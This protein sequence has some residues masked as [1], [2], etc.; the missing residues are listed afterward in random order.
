MVKTVIIRSNNGKSDLLSSMGSDLKETRIT[1]F[2]GYLLSLRPTNLL[3]LFQIKDER[4]ISVQI[5]RKLK[6]Q[7]CDIIVR[8]SAVDYIIEAKLFYEDPT[9]QLLKQKLEYKNIS[10]SEIK[11]IG[12][13][14]N[15]SIENSKAA[16]FDWNDIYNC[17]NDSQSIKI[18]ILCEELKLHLENNGLVKI[19]TPD[20]YAR[21]VADLTS[22]NMFLKAQIYYCPY[23]KSSKIEKCKY[24]APHFS[25][26]IIK[27]SPGINYGI[28]YVAKICG[29]EYVENIDDL[30]KV[31]FQHI[32]AN[33]LRSLFPEVSDIVKNI[34]IPSKKAQILL[35][36][37]KPHLLFNPPIQ[38]DKLQEGSGWLSK[39]YFSFEDFFE[40]ANL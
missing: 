28:S 19:D 1:G 32:K 25:K 7:R 14:N 4:I 13:T 40:A 10:Q 22:L 33:K 9:P 12:I 16:I 29:I 15:K 34:N 36:L 35:L 18:K 37:N 6:S 20:I 23:M 17:L 2:L 8:T 30:K 11:L 31:V 3:K 21:E 24:F 38:K 5:E 27:I 39:Q 26:N